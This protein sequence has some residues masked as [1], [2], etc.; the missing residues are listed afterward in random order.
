MTAAKD[1]KTNLDI[2]FKTPSLDQLWSSLQRCL[3]FEEPSGR[4]NR[5]I[6]QVSRHLNG[7]RDI[8]EASFEEQQECFKAV[9]GTP[10][11]LLDLTARSMNLVLA[12]KDLQTFDSAEFDIWLLSQTNE[13][14]AKE[15]SS[16]E[17][18]EV[19]ILEAIAGDTLSTEPDTTVVP[20]QAQIQY[21]HHAWNI[22]PY[23]R[24]LESAGPWAEDPMAI[25]IARF[26]ARLDLM[27]PTL[28]KEFFKNALSEFDKLLKEE[29]SELPSNF[30]PTILA[31]VEGN[32]EAI[33]LP[34]FVSL[35]GISPQTATV[36]FIS[37]GGANQ[38]LRR[39]LHLRD[40]TVLPILCVLDHDA[41][42]QAATIHDLLRD[43]DRLHVWREGELEDTF[44]ALSLLETLNAYLHSMGVSE[45]LRADELKD[46]EHRTEQ[47]D[48]LWRARGLGNF[49]KV[50]FAQF[51]S[52]RIRQTSDIP[53]DAK[54]LLKTLKSM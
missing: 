4:W 40:T 34:R 27:R 51:Q 6:S 49:D 36:M 52:A 50:G 1:R 41:I 18:E 25:F 35:S 12:L 53:D 47:L 17:Q 32:T 30:Q 38:L 15:L 44:P 11:D 26:M 19:A 10:E 23:W 45:L 28:S 2:S 8:D 42:E 29:R 39:Y 14:N 48:R 54:S 46:G 22:V 24:V 31:L 20:S 21:L 3:I 5:L 7:K 9:F 37:C 33:V 16:T 13:E 43:T